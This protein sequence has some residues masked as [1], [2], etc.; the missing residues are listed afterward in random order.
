[1]C[2]FNIWLGKSLLKS[3][4][5]LANSIFV[6]WACLSL[7]FAHSCARYLRV[8]SLVLLQQRRKRTIPFL[9]SLSRLSFLPGVGALC[10]ALISS[11][12]HIEWRFMDGEIALL[13]EMM[14]IDVQRFLPLSFSFSLCVCLSSL[15]GECMS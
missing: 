3:D 5:M 2:F 8:R 9:C 4:F 6:L 12:L 7:V 11:P 13:K 15:F 10:S 1:M 14:T